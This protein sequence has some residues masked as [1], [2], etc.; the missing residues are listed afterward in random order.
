MKRKSRESL[1]NVGEDS[2]LD[3]IANLVGVLII[4]VAVVSLQAGTMLT[5]VVD[6]GSSEAAL[7]ALKKELLTE[8]Q[9]ANSVE[10]ECREITERAQQL[11]AEVR[12]LEAIRH[13]MLKQNE[14]VKRDIDQQLAERDEQARDAATALRE[15]TEL[16]ARVN[17]LKSQLAR[18][19]E[20]P[21]IERE[22]IV[23]YPTPIAKTVFSNE[24][25]FQLSGHRIAFV[26]IDSL[27]QAMK[28]TWQE[29]I[30]PNDLAS[31]ITGSI[32]PEEG[33]VM[34]YYLSAE[35]ISTRDRQGVN[36]QFDGF[37]L[38]S[39][40]G[41]QT[42]SIEEALAEGSAFRAR[43]DR[44]VPGKTTISVWVYPESYPDFM[45]LKDWLR[46]RGFQIA[47][48]PLA[49]NGKISGGPNG[50]RTSAQ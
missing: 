42:E 2:F 7:E 1:E 47:G 24:V 25:H 13:E 43:L 34:Q 18:A 27:L 21:E 8:E 31:S 23:H 38:N 19:T 9:Q 14:F 3:V 39:V 50:L 5:K 26:P 45:I 20:E 15:R 30:N 29:R 40:A 10:S 22:E 44:M 16:E 35:R 12:A 33:F 28:A 6:S 48:W 4:L 11:N 37:E 36:V 46:E 17:Q 49:E 41:L 32:G